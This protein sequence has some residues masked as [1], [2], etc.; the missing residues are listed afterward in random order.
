MIQQESAKKSAQ[1]PDTR[2]LNMT[3][4]RTAPF[5]RAFFPQATRAPAR[6]PRNPAPRIEFGCTTIAVAKHEK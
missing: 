1:K 6:I 5:A 2:L 3:E 4:S